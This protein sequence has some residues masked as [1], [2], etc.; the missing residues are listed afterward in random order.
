MKQFVLT[1]LVVCSLLGGPAFLGVSN[2]QANPVAIPVFIN[3]NE[4]FALDLNSARIV[5][6]SDREIILGAI[7]VAEINNEITVYQA[8]YYYD[9]KNKSISAEPKVKSYQDENQ[10]WH[11]E[12]ETIGKYLAK[13]GNIVHDA[14]N[15]LYYRVY[16]R[17]FSPGIE[18]KAGSRD[19]LADY[20]SKLDPVALGPAPTAKDM[21]AA[22]MLVEE[23]SIAQ[24]KGGSTSKPNPNVIKGKQLVDDRGNIVRLPQASDYPKTYPY[25]VLIGKG[26]NDEDYVVAGVRVGTLFTDII[27]SLGTPT[28]NNIEYIGN[29]STGSLH[30]GGIEFEDSLRDDDGL[31]AAAI[32]IINRDATTYRGIAVGD[33]LLKVLDAYGKPDKVYDD[34]P[35]WFYG[36]FIYRT[37][38]IAGI[39]FSHDGEKVTKI[40]VKG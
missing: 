15:L 28:K 1:A 18:K 12:T 20:W 36:K 37:D 2:A 4:T 6:K 25:N 32:I 24:P 3:D 16:H 8:Y 14:A 34:E 31:S 35:M 11:H 27:R 13:P 39:F 30:Y 19:I 21:N 23:R 22:T 17:F 38:A 33:S 40:R 9:L 7:T 10:K 29:T 26:L 5:S